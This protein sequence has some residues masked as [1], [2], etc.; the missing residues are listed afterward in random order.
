MADPALS[1]R[2]F[3]DAEPR[4]SYVVA[5]LERAI[6]RRSTSACASTG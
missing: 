1:D 6:D 3:P 2:P 5:R 4:V